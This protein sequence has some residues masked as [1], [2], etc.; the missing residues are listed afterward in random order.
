MYVFP[1]IGLGAILSKAKHISQEMIYASAT[2]LSSTLQ[3]EEFAS[4]MLYPSLDRIR[5]VSIVVA[6]AVIRT[7]RRQKLDREPSIRDMSNDE[8]EKWIKERMYDPRKE[9]GYLE[10]MRERNEELK[11]EVEIASFEVREKLSAKL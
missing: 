9:D 10:L 4:G 3:P 5:E 7:A 6:R 8:L 2:A 11:R 1:G